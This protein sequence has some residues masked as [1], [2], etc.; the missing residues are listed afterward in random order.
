MLETDAGDR[1]PNSERA[2]VELCKSPTLVVDG[3]GRT[4]ALEAVFS[5]DESS[6]GVKADDR[7]G[8][9]VFADVAEL[10]A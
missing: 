2:S 1:L 6:L 4:E 9:A 10:L 3:K 5:I 8:T 7:L